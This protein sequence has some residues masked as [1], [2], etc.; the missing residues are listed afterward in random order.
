MGR[1]HYRSY[2]R[3]VAV[4]AAFAGLCLFGFAAI[5]KW[6]VTTDSAR[7]VS[8]QEVQTVDGCSLPN[9]YGSS[10]ANLLAA[11]EP[12]TV[13]AQDTATQELNRAALRELMDTAPSFN[14]VFVDTA[15]NEV[16]IQDANLWDIRVY[17]R[18]SNSKPGDPP[19]E[20]RRTI[21]GGNTAI[22]FNATVMVDPGNGDIYSNEEDIGDSIVVFANRTTGD[23]KPIRHLHV[24]HRAQ[25]MALDSATGDLFLS[26]SYPP[27]VAIYKSTADDEDRPVRL[28]EG[29]K[30]N[31]SDVHGVALDTENKL[32]YVNSWG[33]YSDFRVAGS[34]RFEPA[35]IEV[36]RED[37][38]GDVAPIRV[39]QGPKTQL[40][41]PGAMSFDP[42]TGDLYV[43]NDVGQSV[44]VFHGNDQGDVAP[45]RV[46]KGPK[47]HLS[48]PIG[49]FA[50]TKNKELWA[51]NFGNSSATVYPL[52][53]NGDVAPLRIIRGAEDN[54]VSLKFGKSEGLAYDTKRDEILVPN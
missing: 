15:R 25:S 34:T 19:T 36:F 33:D 51:A 8:V 47:T 20:P 14:S 42:D 50:D 46:I 30:T 3:K 49:V 12:P 26:I 21:S 5:R 45:S 39:I 48:H 9:S 40:D 23:A 24:T 17:N 38:D 27:Q 52:T 18:L 53:A 32:L 41:W 54:K 16:Y 10:P 37:A 1:K 11:L 35:S 6:F 22:Q 31:L 13:Y 7:L 28:I 29:P 43:A 44:L 4:A 2:R